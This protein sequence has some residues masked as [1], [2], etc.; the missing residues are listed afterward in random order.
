MVLSPPVQPSGSIYVNS[1]T[2][3]LQVGYS[4]RRTRFHLPFSRLVPNRLPQ[5]ALVT[6]TGGPSTV[7]RFAPN[8][9]GCLLFIHKRLL[10]CVP[11]LSF[12]PL[13]PPLTRL[14]D[15]LSRGCDLEIFDTPEH[16]TAAG[17]HYQPPPAHFRFDVRRG[18]AKVYQRQPTCGSAWTCVCPSCCVYFMLTLVT[19]YLMSLMAS[20]TSTPAMLFTG[21]SREWVVL[22]LISPQY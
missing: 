20:I 4:H 13:L 11:T 6:C 16:R 14:A 5:V 17:C 12:L 19:S 8:A 1:K 22:Y 21:T 2:Y 15:L 7:Q 18:T 10:T 3:V 9:R